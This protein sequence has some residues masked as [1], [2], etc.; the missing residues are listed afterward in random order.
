MVMKDK[1]CLLSF[2]AIRKKNPSAFNQFNLYS[3]EH[4]TNYYYHPR[5]APRLLNFILV[6]KIVSYYL[7]TWLC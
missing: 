7:H 5:P 4:W 2:Q 3:A 6:C 1:Q